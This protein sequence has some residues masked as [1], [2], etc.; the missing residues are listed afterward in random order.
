MRDLTYSIK[1]ISHDTIEIRAHGVTYTLVAPDKQSFELTAA[2]AGAGTEHVVRRIL[3][4]RVELAIEDR[5]GTRLT[6]NTTFGA[7]VV[8]TEATLGRRR[9]QIRS[10]P[11][12][13]AAALA[14]TFAGTVGPDARYLRWFTKDMR[15]HAAFRRA[16]R[17][18]L[19][20]LDVINGGPG[21]LACIAVCAC[22]G[23]A[24]VDG[25]I[26]APCCVA[27]YV[28]MLE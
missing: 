14:R 5:E 16:V 8:R 6:L 18:R 11:N 2:K 20:G 28:C 27:C 9:F 3:G 10:R 22:C 4:N 13:H 19:P 23:F 12:E 15:Q 1:P 17:G 25:P 21:T 26:A 24:P 7:R